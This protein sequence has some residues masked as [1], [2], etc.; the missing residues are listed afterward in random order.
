MEVCLVTLVEE[1][2]T[3]AK[4]FKKVKFS[5]KKKL[6]KETDT[7]RKR[8]NF[9]QGFSERTWS[10]GLNEGQVMTARNSGNLG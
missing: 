7:P 9:D 1:A 6:N 5:V 10:G 3:L 4:Y 8:S 2:E